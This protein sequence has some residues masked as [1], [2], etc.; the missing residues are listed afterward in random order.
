MSRWYKALVVRVL[1]FFCLFLWGC[2]FSAPI[3]ITGTWI[4][5]MEWTSG[6]AASLVYPIVLNL[7]HEN[8]ELTGTVRLPSHGSLTFEI[9][10]VQG[11]ARSVNL[12]LVARGVNPWIAPEPTIEFEIEGRFDQ[13]AMSGEGTQSIDGTT[14]EFEWEAVL[15]TEPVPASL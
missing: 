8:R 6:P 11:T 14:Y 12:S 4:G 9:P 3:N 10:I 7:V 5:T 13:T 2:F 1:V 15:V